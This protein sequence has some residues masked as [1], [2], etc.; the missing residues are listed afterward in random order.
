MNVD[1]C[2]IMS[3][4]SGLVFSRADRNV[5][6]PGLTSWPR[7]QCKRKP[8]SGMR[9][10]L[11]LARPEQVADLGQQLLV[12]RQGRRGGLLLLLE[13]HD[14]AEELHHEEEQGRRDDQEV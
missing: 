3:V 8:L 14:P 4:T 6:P 5:C 13:L 11:A 12:L 2:S 10:L 1:G 9:G 7:M